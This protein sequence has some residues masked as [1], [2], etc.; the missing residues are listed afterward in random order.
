LDPD[1]YVQQKGADEYLNQVAS[2]PSYFHWLAERARERFDVRMVE[3]KVDAFKSVLPALQQVS[4]KLERAAIANQLAD[5]FKLDRAVIAD[6]LR[7]TPA[8]KLSSHRTVKATSAV[9]P[10]ELLL[11]ASLLNSGDARTAILHYLNGSDVLRL[12]EL[13]PIFEAVL[14]MAGE[15]VPFSLATLSGRL[16]PR[17]QRILTEISFSETSMDEEQAAQQAIHC[18]RALEHKASR[19]ESV[20]IKTRIRE[21]EQ[22]GRMAEAMQLMSDLERAQTAHSKS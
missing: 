21:L 17:M 9:P 3:G 2:A 7:Q 20:D 5:Y 8:G 16:E 22:Q 1:E 4:D 14:A 6:Q 18:L 13:R 15:G 12:L 11:L 19:T 10:N